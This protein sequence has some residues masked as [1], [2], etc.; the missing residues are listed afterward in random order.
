MKKRISIIALLALVVMLIGSFGI[1][2]TIPALESP[3]EDMI[4]ASI[5]DESGSISLD[6]FPNEVLNF[7]SE[8]TEPGIP[9]DIDIG[10]VLQNKENQYKTIFEPWKTKA[11]IHCVAYDED[12]GFLAMGGGY[13]YDNEVH[14]WRLNM[15]TNEFDKVWDSGDSILR[16]DVISL[17]W[18]DT[19]LNDFIEVAAASSDGF[20]YLFEQRHIYDPQANTENMFDHVWTSPHTFR[21]FD[22]KIYDADRDYRED[23]IV[24]SWDGKVRCFEYTNHSNYPFSEEHWIEYA[25]VWNSGDAIDGRIYTI[26]YGDTNFN[27]L[28]EIIAG[29]REGRVYVFENAGVHL[30]INGEPFPLINDNNYDLV[31]TSQNYTWTPILDMKV[32]E[33]DQTPGEEIALVAQGQGVFILDWNEAAQDYNYQRVYRPWDNWQTADVAPWRLDFW[34]DRVVTA[35]NVTFQLSNGTYIDEPI[36][37]VYIG[38]GLF[39][40]DAEA[41]PYNTGMANTTD[42]YYTTFDAI[43]NPNATAVIDFGNDEEGTGSASSAWDVK[44]KLSSTPS[45]SNIN[46]SVG[47]SA[48]DLE[49]VKIEKMLAMSGYLYIDVDEALGRRQWDWFRYM[50][51][52]VFN[53]VQYLIDSIELM[54]VYNQ[55]TTA[56][57]VAIGPLPEEFNLYGPPN[58]P[59]RLIVADVIGNFYGFKYNDSTTNY[60]LMWDSSRDDFFTLGRNVWDL[61]HVGSETQIPVWLVGAIAYSIPPPSGT[62][63]HWAIGDLDPYD[64]VGFTNPHQIIVM[65]DLNA[66]NVY[67][68]MGPFPELDIDATSY[69]SSITTG[70]SGMRSTIEMGR[71]DTGF[72][73]PYPMAVVGVFDDSI[74][75]DA[76]YGEEVGAQRADVYFFSRS[77]G[78]EVFSFI[79]MEPM[80]AFDFT[81]DIVTALANAKTVPRMTFVDWDEDGDNDLILSTGYLYYC[82]NIGYQG[83]T[84]P[85]LLM[86]QGYFSE[87]NEGKMS[88]YWGQ[89]QTLDIDQ[90][91]DLDLVMS[92]DTRA[93]ATCFLNKGTSDKPQWVQNKK[94]FSNARPE[95]NLKFNDF[96]NL[97]VVPMGWGLP[98]DWWVEYNSEM[99]TLADTEFVILSYHPPDNKMFSFWP[100]YT[101]SSSYI[102]ATYPTVHRYEFSIQSKNAF[103]FGYHVTESWSTE[104][105]LINWTLTITS[106]DVD[107]DGRGE[108]IVGDY[109]N[110]IYIFEHMVNNTYKRAFKSYDINHTE[111]SDTSPYM[112]EEL[113]GISGTFNLVIWDHVEHI[114]ADCDLDGD[115]LKELVAAAGL[116]IYVFEDTGIDDTYELAH[117]IDLRDSGYTASL[118]W[119]NVKGVTAIGAGDDYDLNGENELLVAA[120]PFLFIY[121]IPFD[122]WN[123]TE[124][125]FM[126]T[127]ELEGRFYLVGNGAHEEFKEA[128]IEAMV[129]CDVDED[130]FREVIIGGRINVTQIRQDGFLKIYEWVGATFVEAW[131]AP[132]EVTAWNPITSIVLDDQDYDSAQEIIIG[133][134]RGFDI[135]EWGGTD[136]NYTKV[137]LVTSSPN[138]PIVP[139]KTTRALGIEILDLTFRGDSDVSYWTTTDDDWV[140][141]LFCQD[142]RIYFKMYHKTLDLWSSST[143]LTTGD[144]P[145][146]TGETVISESEPS[147]FL[148]SNGTL[149]A[150]WRTEIWAGATYYDM[151]VAKSTSGPWSAPVRV[152][153]GVGTIRHDPCMTSIGSDTLVWVYVQ[154]SIHQAYYRTSTDWGSW[155]SSSIMDFKNHNDYYINSIDIMKMPSTLLMP[156][157]GYAFAISGRNNTLSKTDLDIMVAFSNSSFIW[158]DS[159]MFKATSSYNNEINPDLGLLAP[160]EN[161]PIVVYESVEAP[162]EDHIQMSYAMSETYMMWRKSE[163]LATLPPY[164]ERI[165]LPGEQVIYQWNETTKIYAPLALSPCVMGL[166]DGG[167]M[168]MHAFDFFTEWNTPK[169]PSHIL[170]TRSPYNAKKYA[171]NADL[172]YGVN[173]S[174]RFTHF[175]I[176]G[177]VDL[178]VGDTDGDA[179]REVIV[180]FDDRVGVYELTHSNVGLE[181]M[182]HE[183]VWLSNKFSQMV[184]GVSIYD[185]NGNGFEEIAISCNRGEVYVFEFEDVGAGSTP[186][187]YSESM[188]TSNIGNMVFDPT[189]IGDPIIVYDL[190]EDGI[191]EIVVGEASGAIRAYDDDG[192]ELWVN[193][194]YSGTPFM[195]TIGNLT[196]IGQPY[197]AVSRWDGNLT[198]LIAQSGT[199]NAH[200]QVA[201]T[202]PDAVAIGNIRGDVLAE[203]VTGS[204]YNHVVALTIGGTILWNTS[205]GAGLSSHSI[206]LGNFS[207]NPANDVVVQINNGSLCFLNGTDGSVMFW[208]HAPMGGDLKILPLADLNND[209]F[210]DVICGEKHLW[211]VDPINQSVLYNSTFIPPNDLRWIWVEDFDGDSMYE[212]LYVTKHGVFLE[213]FTSGRVVWSYEWGWPN[214]DDITDAMLGMFTNNRLGV[215]ICT[216][217]GAVIAIDALTGVV[218]WFDLSSTEYIEL[219]VGDFDGDGIDEIAGFEDT[220]G[221]VYAFNELQPQVPDPLAAFEHWSLY[222][223]NTAVVSRSFFLTGLWTEDLDNDGITEYITGGSD[224]TLRVY[225]PVYPSLRWSAENLDAYVNDVQFADF[226]A[227]GVTDLLVLL[228]KG[229]YRV[230]GFDGATGEKLAAI[231]I[232]SP[233]GYWISHIAVGDFRTPITG[234]EFAVVYVETSTNNTGVAFYDTNGGFRFLTAFNATSFY[235]T[236]VT[237]GRYTADTDDDLCVVGIAFAS[238]GDLFIWEG[239]GNLMGSLPGTPPLIVDIQ[240]GNFN[241]D[242]IEDL[243]VAW[244]NGWVW[245]W[246]PLTGILWEVDMNNTVDGVSVANIDL[247]PTDEIIIN[248]RE[249]GFIVSD[250]STYTEILTYAA[251]TTIAKKVELRD[252]DTDGQLDYVLL[253][254]NKLAIVDM[255]TEE[256]LGAYDLPWDVDLIRV[257][258]FDDQGKLDLMYYYK[259]T[260]YCLTDGTLPPVPPPMLSNLDSLLVTIRT[261]VTFSLAIL[262]L[263]AYLAGFAAWAK[264]KRRLLEKG[265]TP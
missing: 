61:V 17:D 229:G 134:T 200:I 104:A 74:T 124:E 145:I 7:L 21:A 258:N 44:I 254:Y 226:N 165:E 32:G 249:E 62:F 120:G 31:W 242:S 198:I 183:E 34:A 37:Y 149:Y 221:A 51:I 126:K 110:N 234:T 128:S 27:G 59:D 16:A 189:G 246:D 230:I 215:G 260:V 111:V 68:T 223:N 188:W 93:G 109:D 100:T 181:Q 147:L 187:L 180:G 94:L 63:A 164:I 92:Y 47:Q 263:I 85:R 243:A 182:E 46:I 133:H 72:E 49:Q 256:V 208:V 55:I 76:I 237:V 58:E 41:Y 101:Q 3:V 264:R 18:G 135:W 176:R 224:G 79:N 6:N 231:D 69:F 157:G 38:A 67:S 201:P 116:Q 86:H 1:V 97:R 28:P 259:G 112:W 45:V 132:A 184:T 129:L 253:V 70:I 192:T 191:D 217:D 190:D 12:T 26:A 115:G 173:P 178:D 35:N 103:N 255:I 185:S 13:L 186:F 131:E 121:N 2:P 194:L 202:F 64:W 233:E 216:E 209:G 30:M 50:Q 91:G 29:T 14:I 87:I 90:D 172:L 218:T 89:P 99:T 15:E 73:N 161:T 156:G 40:P 167:F 23:I 24:G 56:L 204:I 114:L 117:T 48:T 65:D 144:Y 123:L 251:P 139:L 238:Y 127:D 262:A 152:M 118:G 119:E 95:T 159:L 140:M 52:S 162:I 141:V 169:S 107:S 143:T 60:D 113:E 174:S 122:A 210:D 219:A 33:L 153:S 36:Q 196:A 163:P 240:T 77:A 9:A 4:D 83:G 236:Q 8:D 96:T 177:V 205:L 199:T 212:A 138:Y 88:D 168:Q 106:G 25:E 57:T 250:G 228:A 239:D 39:D 160:P 154:Q 71:I 155:S 102:L 148:H 22:V 252:V 105:D 10:L 75:L 207:T 170:G 171:E 248:V 227:D 5:A 195:L 137:D 108:I 11:A 142:S 42:G 222:W 78:D 197:I 241:G 146:Y 98:Q 125:Y 82:E 225:N 151:W 166:R 244:E 84:V 179:R 158:D 53:G 214:H 20:V 130:G 193:D 150:T 257:G 54:Q 81:G 235:P 232:I 220:T 66:I 211:A 43:S 245:S 136:N 247:S 175:N 203:V 265:N 261:A 213:E 206:A 80:S 19:D